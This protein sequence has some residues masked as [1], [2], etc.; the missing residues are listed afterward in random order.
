MEWSTVARRVLGLV[1]LGWSALLSW[2]AGWFAADPPRWL[3][4]ESVL[5]AAGLARWLTGYALLGAQGARPLLFGRDD[6]RRWLLLAGLSLAGFL[7]W[8]LYLIV[9]AVIALRSVFLPLGIGADGLPVPARP[10][11]LI[12][13]IMSLGFALRAKRSWPRDAVAAPGST[14]E[15]EP[16]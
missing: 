12:L 16:L 7:A 3:V 11:C 4:P 8:P 1:V 14:A 9:E 13:A 5:D 10:G 6:R 2:W 15:S